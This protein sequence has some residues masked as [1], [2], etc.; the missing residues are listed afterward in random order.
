[1]LEC[2]YFSVWVIIAIFATINASYSY[3]FALFMEA[4]EEISVSADAWVWFGV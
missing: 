3:E 4:Y 2:P 1:M